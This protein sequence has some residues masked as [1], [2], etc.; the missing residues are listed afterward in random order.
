MEIPK[1]GE[2]NSRQTEVNSFEAKLPVLW[3]GTSRWVHLSDETQE[4]TVH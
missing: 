2:E 1:L 3:Q 4:E